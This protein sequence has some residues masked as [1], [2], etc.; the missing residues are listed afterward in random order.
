MKLTKL[1]VVEM[2]QRAEDG[3]HPASNEANAFT[4]GDAVYIVSKRELLSLFYEL[5][6]R[7][8]NRRIKKLI[9]EILA[10]DQYVARDGGADAAD[11][12]ER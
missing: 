5:R 1:T 6:P 11:L 2:I 3:G 7:P 4:H 8:P 10:D 12:P 9:E